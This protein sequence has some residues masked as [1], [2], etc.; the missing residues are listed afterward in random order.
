LRKDFELTTVLIADDHALLRGALRSL[1][2]A[3]PDL[4]VIGEAV[5]GREALELT[6]LLRPDVVIT[7]F[8][9]PGAD[10]IEVM[11][12]IRKR[13]LRT[14]VLLLTLYDDRGLMCQALAEGA[15]GY[16]SKS[17]VTEELVAAVRTIARG[18]IYSERQA[19]SSCADDDTGRLPDLS[20]LSDEELSFLLLVSNGY[21]MRQIADELHVGPD[22]V[23]RLR[24]NVSRKLGLHS[25]VEM[26]KV[27]REQGLVAA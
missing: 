10:G 15:A 18:E 24:S 19:A 17:V 21:M 27:A 12:S 6:A 26:L 5:D 1:L 25:R 20:K 4:H 16:L 14:R 7:D 22:E 2:D 3:E 9:M 23:A 11:R 13:S 8:Y